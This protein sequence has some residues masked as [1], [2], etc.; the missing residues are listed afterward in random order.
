MKKLKYF[1]TRVALFVLL[2]PCFL[3][4]NESDKIYINLVGFVFI[5]LLYLF[6]KNTSAK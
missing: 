5:Y 2:V 3:I 1:L 4:F 6:I